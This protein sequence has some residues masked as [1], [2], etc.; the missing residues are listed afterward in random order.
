MGPQKFTAS[1]T[2]EALKMVKAKMG[3]DAMVLSTKDT[4]QGV[5][6]LAITPEDL[7]NMS[8]DSGNPAASSSSD[9]LREEHRDAGRD[10]RSEST[11]SRF[12]ELNAA[13][14]RNK[15]GS[16]AVRPVTL[17]ARAQDAAITP[18]SIAD[19]LQNKKRKQS[20][21]RPTLDAIRY[22]SIR[23]HTSAYVS[24]IH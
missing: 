21:A 15:T 2:A 10:F 1:N 4:P 18:I 17:G 16:D 8:S 7:S 20:Q 12:E 13:N 5:E 6:I 14:L 9:A 23:Q 3:P 11:E 22:I 19:A 24:L